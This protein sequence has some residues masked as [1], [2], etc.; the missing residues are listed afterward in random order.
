MIVDY[1]NWGDVVRLG[2]HRRK[3]TQR[4]LADLVTVS[5]SHIGNIERGETK[6]SY[7]L[8]LSLCAVLNIAEPDAL[9]VESG[10]V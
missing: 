6:P 5:P 10:E 1:T 3:L 7:D 9:T 4:Q 8:V 2:R